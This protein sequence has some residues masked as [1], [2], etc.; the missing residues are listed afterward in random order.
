MCVY[1]CSG[2]AVGEEGHKLDKFFFFLK[3][4]RCGGWGGERMD[5]R[6]QPH[7]HTAAP[8]DTVRPGGFPYSNSFFFGCCC[9]CL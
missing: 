1:A 2:A 7:T 5:F 3:L 8:Y 9:C 6:K 4:G